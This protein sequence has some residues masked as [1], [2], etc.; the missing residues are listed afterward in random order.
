MGTVA[1]AYE[2]NGPRCTHPFD[3]DFL[4]PM[5]DGSFLLPDENRYRGPGF[6]EQ[7]FYDDGLVPAPRLEL[8]AP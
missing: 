2:H 4:V 7:V 8:G 3:I 6:I 5:E 1:H